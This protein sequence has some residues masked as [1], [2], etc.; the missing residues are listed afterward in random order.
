[1]SHTS[2]LVIVFYTLMV[3]KVEKLNQNKI[4]YIGLCLCTKP[5]SN[6]N[7]HISLSFTILSLFLSRLLGA[8]STKPQNYSLHSLSFDGSSQILSS[9]SL[10]HTISVTPPCG[11]FDQTLQ[12]ILH[13][14]SFESE[15]HR[16][17]HLLPFFTQAPSLRHSLTSAESIASAAV[18]FC[19]STS[20]HARF[21]FV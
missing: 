16:S 7:L 20:S 13:S 8:I 21:V 17:F 5:I 12:L 18:V 14:L 6:S 3:E 4:L 9:L 2:S 11:D 15:L 1:M 19:T 10:L